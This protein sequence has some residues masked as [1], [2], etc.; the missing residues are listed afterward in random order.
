MSRIDRLRKDIEDLM[1]EL[2]GAIEA[3]EC[4]F[5]IELIKETIKDYREDLRDE[6]RLDVVS[7]YYRNNV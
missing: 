7:N 2:E 6:E 3:G 1:V 4:E 5:A